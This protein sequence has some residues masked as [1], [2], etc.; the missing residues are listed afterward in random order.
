MESI[1]ERTSLNDGHRRGG[2]SLIGMYG[3][4][5]QPLIVQP[6][7]SYDVSSAFHGGNPHIIMDVNHPPSSY[8]VVIHA[9]TCACMDSHQLSKNIEEHVTL[10][11]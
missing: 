8:D 7:S 2:R 6:R 11:I 10:I 3:Y 5:G 1:K 9:Y 4:M